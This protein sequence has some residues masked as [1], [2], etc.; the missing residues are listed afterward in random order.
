MITVGTLN[1]CIREGIEG[2]VLISQAPRQILSSSL[3]ESPSS[4]DDIFLHGVHQGEEKI[5]TDT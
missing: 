3:R 2:L 1:T 4:E 5:S